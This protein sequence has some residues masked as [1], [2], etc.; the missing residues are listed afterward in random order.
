MRLKSLWRFLCAVKGN[1]RKLNTCMTSF[2]FAFYLSMQRQFLLLLKYL[3]LHFFPGPKLLDV[4]DGINDIEDVH[5]PPS[6]HFTMIFNTFVFMTLF[7]EVNARKIHNQHN[8]FSGICTNP[9]FIG[10]WI[11]TILA[12]VW[13]T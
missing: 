1:L 7:N 4:D 11:G 3:Y 10:I 9:I 6:I 12:Q 13:F 2:K 8:I 5:A